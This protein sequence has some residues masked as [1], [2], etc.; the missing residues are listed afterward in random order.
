MCRKIQFHKVLRICNQG[1]TVVDFSA[2]VVI[3][4]STSVF[5]SRRNGLLYLRKFC[6]QIFAHQELVGP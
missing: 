4:K 1:D 2:C 3:F 6:K 5:L